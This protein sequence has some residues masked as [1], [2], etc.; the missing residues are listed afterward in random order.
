MSLFLKKWEKKTKY[1]G[2]KDLNFC[3]VLFFT[4]LFRIWVIL[5]KCIYHKIQKVFEILFDFFLTSGTYYYYSNWIGCERIFFNSSFCGNGNN[6]CE[7]FV[8]EKTNTQFCFIMTWLLLFLCSFRS[9]RKVFKYSICSLFADQC[10]HF[11]LWQTRSCIQWAITW[12]V[13]LPLDQKINQA[14][15]FL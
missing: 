15:S 13:W 3:T 9:I 5:K 4:Y 7:D 14:L 6:S 2:E 8:F 12:L 11:E 10:F 1:W